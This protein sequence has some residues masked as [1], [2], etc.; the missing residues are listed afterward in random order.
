LSYRS[1]WFQTI[2]ETILNIVRE[3]GDPIPSQGENGEE[4]EDTQVSVSIMDLCE[5]TSIRKEDIL[6]TLE[7]SDNSIS[8]LNAASF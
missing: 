4:E 1:Y 5:L 6:Q 7:V 8:M 3:Q 2:M